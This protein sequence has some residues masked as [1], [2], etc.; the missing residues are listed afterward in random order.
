LT[1]FIQ[2]S[3]PKTPCQLIASKQ[4]PNSSPGQTQRLPIKLVTIYSSL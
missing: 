3:H 1:T 4:P 2:S